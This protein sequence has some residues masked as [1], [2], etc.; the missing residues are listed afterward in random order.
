M[1]T[2]PKCICYQREDGLQHLV[3][4]GAV[5]VEIRWC[6]A[7][8]DSFALVLGMQV[9]NPAWLLA[10][11]CLL[12][13]ETLGR[14]SQQELSFFRDALYPAAKCRRCYFLYLFTLGKDPFLEFLCNK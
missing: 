5:N 7:G 1:A 14:I 4:V 8:G 12:P 10:P 3:V 11:E 9:P 6:V 2:L 13:L